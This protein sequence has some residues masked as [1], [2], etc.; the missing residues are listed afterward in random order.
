MLQE[1]K[2]KSCDINCSGISLEQPLSVT[3]GGEPAATILGTDGHVLVES[4][5]VN[6]TVEQ[7]DLPGRVTVPPYLHS[8]ASYIG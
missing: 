6:I 7:V 4:N 5:P 2:K 8:Q 1:H 3:G